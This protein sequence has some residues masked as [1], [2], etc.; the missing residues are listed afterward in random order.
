MRPPQKPEKKKEKFTGRFFAHGRCL[1]TG[2]AQKSAG[3]LLLLLLRF[4]KGVSFFE[5]SLETVIAKRT[6]SALCL[7]LRLAGR[8]VGLL[9]PQQGAKEGVALDGGREEQGKAAGNTGTHPRRTCCER[10]IGGQRRSRAQ[11]RRGG[12]SRGP[13][14]TGRRFDLCLG[15][16]AMCVCSKARERT[17]AHCP[18][19]ADPPRVTR[20]IS[21]APP[22]AAPPAPVVAAAPM[23]QTSAA[24][25][26]VPARQAPFR[27]AE[28]DIPED[29]IAVSAKQFATPGATQ[30]G[31]RERVRS[32]STVSC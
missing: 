29:V 23:E 21:P 11:P 26:P 12:T 30:N 16:A 27:G 19:P 17:A 25:P 7:L 6:A 3:K 31:E 9:E 2:R 28:P 10:G 5:F 32:A 18:T 1:T 8:R 15:S 20:D 13:R 4:L 24:P 22:P 14:C